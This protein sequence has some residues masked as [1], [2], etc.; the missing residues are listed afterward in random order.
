MTPSSTSRTSSGG[1]ARHWVGRPGTSHGEMVRITKQGSAELLKIPGVRNFGA[2]IGQGTLADEPVGINSGEN[3]ISI[4]DSADYDK[5]VATIRKVVEGY[6]GLQRDVETYL[7]ERRKEVL[8]GTSEAIVVRIS[9]DDFDV[10]RSK[11]E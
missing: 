3:W 11:A 10:L 5:T 8:T 9:G 7:N 2:H 4:A 6:P 1:F